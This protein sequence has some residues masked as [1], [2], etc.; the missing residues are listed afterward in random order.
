MVCASVL[1][2]HT[3]TCVVIFHTGKTLRRFPVCGQV[4]SV[5]RGVFRRPGVCT[6]NPGLVVRLR[7]VPVGCAWNFLPHGRRC[8]D[9]LSGSRV[10]LSR[11]VRSHRRRRADLFLAG[12]RGVF[13][14][15]RAVNFSP[16]SKL[17][18]E[19]FGAQGV[20]LKDRSLFG[21]ETSG[22]R[23]QALSKPLES[24]SA[25]GQEFSK[26]AGQQQGSSPL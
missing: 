8:V 10:E 26:A 2:L 3:R 1:P 19:F 21:P 9:F 11:Q 12:S 7:V 14:V 16:Q 23:R 6:W 4:S 24:T 18:V 5:G 20:Q 13:P 22:N 17:C 15:R 25:A